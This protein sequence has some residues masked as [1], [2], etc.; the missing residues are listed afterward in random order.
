MHLRQSNRQ[1]V[2]GVGVRDTNSPIFLRWMSWEIK[3]TNTFKFV[4]STSTM[5]VVRNTEVENIL[6][7]INV[8]ASVLLFLRKFMFQIWRLRD[9]IW[10]L[11]SLPWRNFVNTR[12]Q[13]AW[14][15]DCFVVAGSTKQSQ[16]QNIVKWK[17][18]VINANVKGWNTKAF[19]KH[20]RNAH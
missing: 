14:L 19:V 2:S 5:I 1:F 12:T 20:E 7:L 10:I 13:M 8:E 16:Q 6:T 4:I 9:V 17:H 18:W 15:T 3:N 11:Y